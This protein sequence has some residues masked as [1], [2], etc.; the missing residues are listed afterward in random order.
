VI[1]LVGAVRDAC[2]MADT[3]MIKTIG[4]H[5][6]CATLARYNWAPALTR[7][8]IERT[9]I[10]AVGTHISSRP[11]IEI[12]V[13]TTKYYG[14]STTWLLGTEEPPIARSKHEWFVL[15]LLPPHLE[16]P[17]WAFVV[18]RD[19]VAAAT[20]IEHRY[21]SKTRTVPK[22]K[23]KNNF[24]QVK[25]LWMTWLWYANRWD[26]LGTPTADVPVLLSKDLLWMMQVEGVGLPPGH[27]WNNALP[28]WVSTPGTARRPPGWDLRSQPAIPPIGAP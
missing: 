2:V 28:E 15:V 9:D 3:K 1:S 8:G 26:L 23:R 17:P 21:R 27:P 12:Q 5:W 13:K 6:V 7:D 4:E 18:P 20:W 14:R 16:A 24:R 25:I 10:L 22:Q 19:H 11:T